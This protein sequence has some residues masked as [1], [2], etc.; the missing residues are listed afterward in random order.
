MAG[1][2]VI[3]RIKVADIESNFLSVISCELNNQKSSGFIFSLS[4]TSTLSIKEIQYGGLRTS[5][6]FILFT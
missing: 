3:R 4:E 1:S 5:S 6:T 2:Y